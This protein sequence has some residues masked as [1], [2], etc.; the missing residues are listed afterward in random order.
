M[1]TSIPWYARIAIKM[2]LAWL[3]IPYSV[4]K[5]IGI[6]VHGEMQDPDYVF[7][8]FNHH[9]ACSG[10]SGRSALTGLEMGPGDSVGS[11]VIAKAMGFSAFYLVDAGDHANRNV[12]IYKAI[13]RICAQKGFVAPDVERATGFDDILTACGASYATN[14]LR[15]YQNIPTAS[16]DL[17]FSQ[18]VLEHVR[19]GE[20]AQIATE[21]RRILKPDGI[22][23]HQVD[24]SDHLGGG[25]NNMRIASRWW[26]T[27]F[28]A[29]SGFYTNRLRFSEMC[30]ILEQAGFFVE[31]VSAERWR[32]APIAIEKLALEFRHF[33]QEDLLVSSFHVLLRPRS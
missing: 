13:S 10:L 32:S 21:M 4:W 9:L 6:Y 24:L 18:A 20:F 23:S 28:M 7:R 29:S 17:I 19:R 15:S 8:V 25:L 1:K 12:E 30:N 31:V 14:G 27:E 2:A 33:G 26:E 11:A 16:V 5:R 3:P 22:A